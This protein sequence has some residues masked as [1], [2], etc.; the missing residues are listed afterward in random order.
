MILLFL[1]GIVWISCGRIDRIENKNGTDLNGVLVFQS[2]FEPSSEVI[3]R[4]SDAD[5]VGK[6]NSFSAQ[7]DWV[8]NLDNHPEIGN[9][10]L[11]Y[12]GGDELMR[13]AKIVP[14]PVDP[15]NHVLQFWLDKPNVGGSKGRIQ[16]N[17]YGGSGWKEFY[18]S[19]RMYLPEDFRTVR[20]FPEKINWLTIAE[21]WNNV[22][23]SQTVP[24]GFRITLGIGKEVATEGDLHFILDAQDCELF[25][26]DRQKYTTLWSEVNTNISVP[27]GEWFTMEYYYKEGNNETGRFYMTIETEKGKKQVVFDHKGFTHNSGDPNPNGV[28]D[29]NPLKL[30]TSKKLI[31]YMGSQ[32]K[33][34][35]IY[36]DD[37][38]LWKNKKLL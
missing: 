12:Q 8:A 32:G 16:A 5:I 10:N 15:R 23:W 22:T 6:D 24:Y 11:Q 36:W 20:T 17:L 25:A 26:D 37:F 7:N 21:F 18:Q 35:Q 27:I 3:A 30:Y 19:V 14:D 29:F 13:W 2:G 31:D 33:T 9:F 38:Y 28:S 1:A 34:L 4:G